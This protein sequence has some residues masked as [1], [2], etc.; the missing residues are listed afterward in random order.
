MRPA[1]VCG[2]RSP[3]RFTA[4]GGP[5]RTERGSAV[6]EFVFLGVLMIVPLVY[7]V[8]TLAR[9]QAGTYAV[10]AAAREAGR[11]F[12]TA[13]DE[14]AGEARAQAAAAIAFADHDFAGV[15]TVTISCRQQPCLRPGGRVGTAAQVTVPLPLVPS[16]ARRVVPLELPV[17]ATHLST[18]DTFR[19]QP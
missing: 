9:I 13:S 1:L 18:V 16:F 2:W 7:L 11:A 6:V 15:G 17:S 10:T 3:R 19:E 5:H 14:Q 12:V 4:E 8:M